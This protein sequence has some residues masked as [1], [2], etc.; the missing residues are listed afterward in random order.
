MS[1]D[2]TFKQRVTGHA[3][4]TVQ[5]SERRLSHCVEILQ[6]GGAA[7]VDDNTATRVVRCG[8]H[9]NW[10]RGDIDTVFEAA[11]VNLG[12]MAGYKITTFV[13]DVEVKTVSS[14]AFHLVIYGARHNIARSEFSGGVE[15]GHKAAAIRQQQ[16][17]T[18]TAQ[19]LCY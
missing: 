16:F 7:F 15:V 3:V 4:G 11:L 10:C 8:Y 13:T 12:K 6:I 2:Q 1:V 18:F 19:R 14:E 5:A 9:W 17:G